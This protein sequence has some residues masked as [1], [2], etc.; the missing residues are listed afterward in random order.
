MIFIGDVRRLQPLRRL[1]LLVSTLA[2]S[3]CETSP[4]YSFFTLGVAQ[5]VGSTRS[6]VSATSWRGLNI[7]A[8]RT[9]HE[10]ISAG[11]TIGWNYLYE[12][13]TAPIVFDRGAAQGAAQGL[14]T[15]T[16]SVM[17]VLGGAQYG[18]L[19][20]NDSTYALA[21]YVGLLVGAYY[22]EQRTS[23]GLFDVTDQWWRPGIAPQIGATKRVG[24]IRL[25]AD[26]RYN[27]AIGGSPRVSYIG[28]STG[29][30]W[31]Y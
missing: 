3:A 26:L 5:P 17:P 15:R 22:L 25:I 24:D 6:Y 13:S 20:R 8:R 31:A 10:H 16:L 14:H 2:L 7:E 12:E 1:L 23:L 30:S 19:Q 28:L 21:P 18:P 11:Y 27:L 4:G 29:F 9:V